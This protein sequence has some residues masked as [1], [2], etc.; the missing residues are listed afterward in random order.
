MNRNLDSHGHTDLHFF[1][2]SLFAISKMRFQFVADSVVVT[3]CAS[4]KAKPKILKFVA[5]NPFGL[6]WFIIISLMF[7]YFSKLLFSGFLQF[8]GDFV[9][10]QNTMTECLLC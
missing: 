5:C 7:C 2:G 3:V 10:G 1:L 8:E 4:S 9:C 6:L